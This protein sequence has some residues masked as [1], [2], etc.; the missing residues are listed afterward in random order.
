MTF[1]RL[2]DALYSFQITQLIITS[3]PLLSPNY[4]T[5]D[6]SLPVKPLYTTLITFIFPA[7]RR[8]HQLN[9]K[10]KASVTSVPPIPQQLTQTSRHTGITAGE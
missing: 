6:T 3:T 10:K 8:G 1:P 4:D 9:S 5:G 7:S 2:V